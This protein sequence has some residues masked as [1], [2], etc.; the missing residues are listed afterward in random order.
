MVKSKNCLIMKMLRY[1]WLALA[2]L[3]STAAF[4]KENVN[5]PG[6]VNHNPQRP[7]IRAA[8]CNPATAQVDLN[9]NNVRARLRQGGDKW[10]D[11]TRARYVIPNVAPGEFEVSSLFAGA[12][13]LGGIDDQDNLLCAA[14]TYRQSGN[15]FWAGPLVD[16]PAINGYTEE[17]TCRSWDRF[18]TVY[19]SEIDSLRF[20]IL[21]NGTI[22]GVIADNLL[23]WPARGNTNFVNRYGFPLPNQNLAPFIDYD[24]DG[25]YDPSRGDHPYIEVRGCPE[26]NYADPVYGDQMIWWVYNDAGNVHTETQGEAM[27]MEIQCTAFGYKTSD[28]F[29]NMSF[30]RYK[31]INRNTLAVDSTYFTVWTDPDLGCP[32]DDYIGCNME[33][34]P[35]LRGPQARGLGIVYNAD[36]NDERTGCGDANGYGN[37]I[38][39][40]GVDYFRGPLGNL[41][42]S[43]QVDYIV[44]TPIIDLNGDTIGYDTE[45]F[46]K[47]KE[48]GLSSFMYFVNNGTPQGNPQ[49]AQEHYNL[50]RGT[51]RN[52]TPLT[53]SG[54]GFQ[55]AGSTTLFAFPGDA[56]DATDW[57]MCSA[58]LAS[59]DYRYLH[60][61][62]PFRLLPGRENELITGV[63]WIPEH[64]TSSAC[65]SF[66]PLLEADDKAQA[67]FDNCFK[68]INGPNA[69]DLEIVELDKEL[70][71]MLSNSNACLNSKTCGQAYSEVDPFA[72]VGDPTYDFE[73]YK[74]YQVNSPN[75]SVT[76]LTDPAKAQLIFQ[77]D[78]RN[79]VTQIINWEDDNTVG[80]AV[81]V[82]KTEIVNNNGVQTSFRLRQDA[83]ASNN[84]N[85]VNH[86]KYYFIAVAYGFNEYQPYDV[87]TGSGQRSPYLQ[88]RRNVKVY[89]GI[90]RINAPEYYGVSYNTVYGQGPLQVD[91]YDGAGNTGYF[92]RV[93]NREAVEA[94]VIA[95][96]NAEMISYFGG[97]A[98][99]GI[100][101]TNPLRVPN[102]SFYLRVY[103]R[104]ITDGAITSPAQH[105][106]PGP[107][108]D[109]IMWRLTSRGTNEEWVSETP[110]TIDY[111]QSILE[112]GITLRAVHQPEPGN[113]EQD[114]DGFVGGA[115]E[116]PDPSKANWIFGITDDYAADNVLR[117]GRMI[118]AFNFLKTSNPITGDG[119][120]DPQ[121]DLSK[122]PTGFYPL[123]LWDCNRI[124]SGDTDPV[125]KP[126][127]L[128]V[129]VHNAN[130]C[131]YLRQVS[132]GGPSAAYKNLRNVD[133]V[134]TPDKSKWSRCLVVET[135]S[136]Y[137]P[138]VQNTPQSANYGVAPGALLDN[139]A[140]S[141]LGY[142]TFE[143][144][145]SPSVDIN[146]NPDPSAP[147]PT[148][149]SYFP[150]YAYDV[151]T[152]ERLNIY[153]GENT[154]F[155]E[156]TTGNLWYLWGGGADVTTGHDMLF[157]PTSRM[158][159]DVPND[160]VAEFLDDPN[161]IVAGG[162][163]C[164]FVHNSI[165]DGCAT[166]RAQYNSPF[167]KNVVLRN[168]IWSGMFMLGEGY[169][170]NNGVPP[171]EAIFQLRVKKPFAT[172]QATGIN[173]GF[174][175]Y[176]FSL[177]GFETLL[178]QGEVAE[179]ALDLIN[180]V[181]NPYY[182]YSE[183]SGNENEQLIKITNL[184]PKCDISIY[185]IDGRLVKAYKKDENLAAG[186][187]RVATNNVE[188]Q[189]VT[190]LNWDL[191]NTNN[192][193]VASG[194]Y[195]IRVQVPGVGER[196]LK[197][198]IVQRAFDSQRL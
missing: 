124:V 179:S 164:I 50:M 64:I 177:K 22:D 115:V 121:Q 181:P 8:D 89:T 108:F 132:N 154:V 136:P 175:M 166:V 117:F 19:G 35:T 30:Y 2:V 78:V 15:D 51:W 18:F 134:I 152:G 90:P 139:Y 162:Q 110:I 67:L 73:G 45:T 167:R 99:V 42:D 79:G 168:T 196:T 41:D 140:G 77:T 133:V 38:P 82:L 80:L 44:E 146:G 12:V 197:A 103:D 97:S 163:H 130:S 182:A 69:P 191:T 24:G 137:Y 7:G 114:V 47:K 142:A 101:I 4:A 96:N 17:T 91:R 183:Y 160:G 155:N 56:P 9:I 165:Y 94:Q 93:K 21:D 58:N 40:L 100:F 135:A 138:G 43:T 158:F 193:P 66:Q 159:V 54:T 127:H 5:S 188:E 170:M 14:Q 95:N 173:N 48:V 26:N 29:N 20:D 178:N 149:W 71:I 106:A 189:I 83:F 55:T 65:V 32:D 60:T 176:G 70:I 180:V 194:V 27:Y 131:D 144:R 113:D 151:S 84:R 171:A 59:D 46:Y 153:F 125:D 186:E 98:P 25:A 16:N 87:S 37:P 23:Y 120:W 76:E 33:V 111:D 198:F 185:S 116:F 85:L 192:V 72:V 107:G 61:S 88:G 49:G 13:W 169:A 109:T 10:W 86:R 195:L 102:D 81:P 53:A 62:G 129:S 150:G 187:R 119:R 156:D 143:M 157:N 122:N 112:L 63:V 11:G 147:N 105:L 39:A 6:M 190:S 57:S 161:E 141:Y 3:I 118:D 148:G 128:S 68:L 104:D 123:P 74:I 92:L 174:P 31:L 28:E 34:V 172:K 184:P 75:V 145:K 52:G 1:S 36:N 126:F